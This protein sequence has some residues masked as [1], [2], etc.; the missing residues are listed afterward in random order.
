MT[1]GQLTGVN[2]DRAAYSRSRRQRQWLLFAVCLSVAVL[3][4]FF[5][6]ETRQEE[7]YVQQSDGWQVSMAIA[8]DTRLSA[9]DLLQGRGP[10]FL[11][12][13]GRSIN[14]GYTRAVVWLHVRPARSTGALEYLEIDNAPLDKVDF[15][16]VSGSQVQHLQSLGDTRPFFNRE[17]S[18]RNFILPL[19]SEQANSYMVRVQTQ[20][21]LHFDLAFYHP[22][23]FIKHVQM[24][25]M[26]NGI[27]LGILLIMALYNLLFFLMIGD[28]AHLAYV[29]YVLLFGFMV[30]SL[31]GL[32]QQYLWPGYPQG[33]A[34]STI[35]LVSLVNISAVLFARAFLQS[36]RLI[37]RVDRFLR[38]LIA[39]NVVLLPVSLGV[40]FTLAS[41]MVNLMGLIMSP[42]V[43]AAGV[44]CWLQG[45]R[46]ARFLVLAWTFLMLTIFFTGLMF[47]GLLPTTFLTTYGMQIGSGVE[48][49]LLS[50][51]LSDKMALI[52]HDKEVAQQR[53]VELLMEQN[54]EL[55]VAVMERTRSLESVRASL[56]EHNRALEN[57]NRKLR[58]AATHDGLTG[59]L[60]HHAFID[61][62]A[63]LLTDADRYAYPVCLIMI[64]LDYFKQVNDRYGHEVGNE[65]LKAV[66]RVFADNVRDSDL[67]ARYGGEEFVLALSHTDMQEGRAKAGEL[68]L[69]IQSLR[70]PEHP[71]LRI[72]ASMGVAP[73]KGGDLGLALRHADEAL[74]RAKA[75]GRGRVCPFRKP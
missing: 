11:A 45:F 16:R 31:N 62:L 47:L 5:L 60:N 4:L 43:L 25:L 66:A 51:A 19:R 59:L 72:N 10:A 49:V 67:A 6:L 53:A 20:G 2:S 30:V 36:V 17:I 15:Y 18:Y 29:I 35:V 68:L 57:A 54:R 34:Y 73:V 24:D 70:Q 22:D 1:S 13:P 75:L 55:D 56:L 40:D 27:Y 46:P 48:I 69:Q 7:A 50:W 38:I 14:L 41:R 63:V 23:A 9:A 58:E 71:Q 37:P 3:A 44:L 8:D 74:Y 21:A 26:V 61:E 52:K 65:V 42:L 64:D 12:V 28:R 33:G 32:G 39:I